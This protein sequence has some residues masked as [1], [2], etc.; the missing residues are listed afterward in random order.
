M[1]WQNRS[2]L[3]EFSGFEIAYFGL[4]IGDHSS[5][6]DYFSAQEFKKGGLSRTIWT[7]DSQYFSRL[8]FKADLVNYRTLADTMM[9]VFCK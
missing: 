6:T 1:L 2:D 5:F 9:D 8:Y 7:E 3:C 4:I